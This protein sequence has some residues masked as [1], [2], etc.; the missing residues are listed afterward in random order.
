MLRYILSFLCIV[1]GTDTS[2]ETY[3]VS[4]NRM[5]ASFEYVK[6]S[7]KVTLTAP[8]KGWFL[9]GFNS[10][11]GLENARLV[12]VRVVDNMVELEEHRTSFKFPMPY[13]QINQENTH[14]IHLVE[15]TS[16]ERRSSVTFTFAAQSQNTTQIDMRKEQPLY[17]T[18]AYSNE[19]DFN[20]HSVMRTTIKINE[21]KPQGDK[22]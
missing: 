13:H 6:P 5:E 10:D 21:Y 12:F 7:M 9:I 19:V 8:N 2:A 15:Y 11:A 20:H 4:T 18:L 1:V 14:R 17:I 22:I 3:Q 16:D